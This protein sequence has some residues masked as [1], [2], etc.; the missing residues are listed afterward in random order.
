MEWI[1]SHGL[2]KM[3]QRIGGFGLRFVVPAEMGALFR[4]IPSPRQMGKLELKARVFQISAMALG[5]EQEDCHSALVNI[6]V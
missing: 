3:R 5:L 6:G 2:I 4:A 1:S